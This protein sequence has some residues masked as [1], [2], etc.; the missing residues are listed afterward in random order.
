MYGKKKKSQ[1]PAVPTVQPEQQQKEEEKQPEKEQE[2]VEPGLFL[3]F[4]GSCKFD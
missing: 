1:K 4:G 3:D 2:K